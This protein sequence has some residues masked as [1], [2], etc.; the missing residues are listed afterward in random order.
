MGYM[1]PQLLLSFLPEIIKM[2]IR[3]TERNAVKAP[4]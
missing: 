3:M 4:K 2:I 1:I